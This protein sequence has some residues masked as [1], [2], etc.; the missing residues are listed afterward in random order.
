LEIV[1]VGIGQF[2]SALA[3][4]YEKHGLTVY[5]IGKSDPWPAAN[6]SRIVVLCVQTQS[7]PELADQRG[8][9]LASESIIVST[10][11]GLVQKTGQTASDYLA[12]RLEIK[13]SILA[14]SGPSFAS[15][16]IGGQPA[17]LVLAGKDKKRIE[18][19]SKILV[20]PQLRVYLSQD[21]KGVE[22][23]G[24]LKNIYAIAAGMSEGLGFENNARA[25]LITRSLSEMCRIVTALGGKQPT[26][27]G[28]AGA[29][30]LFLTCSSRKSRNYQF[31][32][33]I[34]SGR[35]RQ[36]LMDELGTVEGAWTASVAKNI[37][38]KHRVRTPIIDAVNAV[39][40]RAISPQEAFIKLMSRKIRHEFD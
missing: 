1:V 2:G 11:K 37:C 19:A 39:L 24:A 12:K 21:P 36:T 28:L 16:L 33:G 7:L 38:R 5:R 9:L 35:D 14:L 20:S 8:A 32:L 22:L 25:A 6:G 3:R 26:C 40:A 34:A 15:E 30:D 31:G 23:C 27:F 18:R 29:G 10:A 13:N 4:I 17:A